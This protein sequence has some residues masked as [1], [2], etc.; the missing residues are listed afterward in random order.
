LGEAVGLAAFADQDVRVVQQPVDGGGGDGLG[1]LLVKAGGVQG[2]S[3]RQRAPLVGGVDDAEE[4]FGC[5][6]GN[7]EHPDVIDHDRIGT[8]ESADGF[9]DGV[10]GAVAPNEGGE[11][12][13]GVPGDGLAVVDREVTERF[14]EVRFAGAARVGV[15]LLMFVDPLPER[16]RMV[17]APGDLRDG[18]LEVHRWRTEREQRELVLLCRLVDGSCGEIPAA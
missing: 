12:F 17:A 16:V 18:V 9:G 6:E 2:A 14:N 7:R 10:V 13:Q 3:D 8:D 4:R 15:E 5:L 11:R 1:H